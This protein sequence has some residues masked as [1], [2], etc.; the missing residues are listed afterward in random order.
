LPV[1]VDEEEEVDLWIDAVLDAA[2]GAAL[3]WGRMPKSRAKMPDMSSMARSADLVDL[4]AREEM[5]RSEQGYRGKRREKRS[6]IGE[7]NRKK[8]KK[9]EE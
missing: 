6:Q 9:R 7:R 8:K 2:M 3:P 4:S 5:M 1:Q